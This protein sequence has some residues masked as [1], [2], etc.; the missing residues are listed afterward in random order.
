MGC[1]NEA[2]SSLRR[3]S[4]LFVVDP[5]TRVEDSAPRLLDL[6]HRADARADL[7]GFLVT[8]RHFRSHS[9]L[10]DSNA[11]VR[12]NLIKDRGKKAAVGHLLSAGEVARDLEAC[13]SGSF[14]RIYNGE[15][16]S[17]S[18]VS[19]AAKALSIS[20]DRRVHGA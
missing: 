1:R 14:L 18:I 12:H 16:K 9:P 13:F 5:S 2:R 3:N 4:P 19:A 6:A 17:F 20:F 7:H 11:R 15:M 8:D 10:G